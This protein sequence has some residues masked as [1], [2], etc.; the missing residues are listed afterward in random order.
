MKKK[1]YSINKNN[2]LD[3]SP[4]SGSEHNYDP[5]KW[6]KNYKT[7]NS[8]NC[9]SYAL[10]KIV[11]KLKSKAQPG[12]SSAFEHI[13]VDNYKCSAFLNR[14]KKDVPASYLEY[15]D[16]P[17]LKGFYKIFLTLDKE[18]DYHW[19]RQDSNSRWSHKPGSSNVTN[20]DADDKIIKNPMKAKR[21]YG[22]LNYKTPCFYA[23]IYSDLSRA[24]DEIYDLKKNKKGL[25]FG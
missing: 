5:D 4:K 18:N 24:L 14:L 20:L 6:N 21:D 10:G 16:K 15:F 17:C 2:K 22:Y 23:C 12:Y 25:F 13:D 19:Y 7:K 1:N 3:Y 9:Y 8:H 11:K